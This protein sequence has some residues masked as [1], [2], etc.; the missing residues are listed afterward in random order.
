MNDFP[1]PGSGAGNTS[2]AR[3]ARKTSMA[4][5]KLSAQ[6]DSSVSDVPPLPSLA[7]DDKRQQRF[8]RQYSNAARAVKM[9]SDMASGNQNNNTNMPPAPR[10][11]D[12]TLSLRT[13]RQSQAPTTAQNNSS[14]MSSTAASVAVRQPRKSIGPSVLGNLLQGKRQQQQQQDQPYSTSSTAQPAV[15]RSPSLTKANRRASINPLQPP[16]EPAIPRAML[17]TRASS[18]ICATTSAST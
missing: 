12:A 13:R 3:G 7:M 2:G 18:Q 9:S 17:P 14:T 8:P 1:I 11:Q 5:N 16:V 4:K 15:S 6:Q 10:T